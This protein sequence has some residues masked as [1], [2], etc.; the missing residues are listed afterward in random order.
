MLNSKLLCSR[1]DVPSAE[2]R[3]V[4][5]TNPRVRR[6]Q[7]V[8]REPHQTFQLLLFFFCLMTHVVS[9]VPSPA[10]VRLQKG[11]SPS[12]LSKREGE[13][14]GNVGQAALSVTLLL[15]KSV[16]GCC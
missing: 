2:R 12:P 3:S 15:A 6:V 1:D 5:P 4:Y 9:E 13:S 7:S 10:S 14:D 11:L 8:R 16:A